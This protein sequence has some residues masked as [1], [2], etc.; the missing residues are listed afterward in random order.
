MIYFLKSKRGRQRCSSILFTYN[1]KNANDLK[2][3]NDIHQKTN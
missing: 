1:T 3:I 2:D